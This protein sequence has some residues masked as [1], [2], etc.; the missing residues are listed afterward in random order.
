MY[1]M[2]NDGG[3]MTASDEGGAPVA[4]QWTMLDQQSVPAWVE[5]T[6]LL[7][8]VDGTEEFYSAEDLAEKLQEDG[9][10]P[11]H[12]SIAVW[13]SDHLAAFAQLRVKPGLTHQDGHVRA[14]ITAG[15]HP[16][17]R[18]RGIGRE[19][20][21]RIEQRAR[22]LAA[23]RHPGVPLELRSSGRL[24][25][26]PVRPF[27]AERGYSPARYFTAMARPLPGGDL[28]EIDPRAQPLTPDLHEA[29]RLAHNDAFASHWGSAPTSAEDWQHAVCAHA[30]RPQ[31][32][33]VVTEER[34][35]PSSPTVLAYCMAAQWVDRELYV[36]LVGTRPSARGRGLARAVLSATISTGAGSGAFEAIELDVDSQSPQGADT[37]YASLG[38]TAVR[39]TAVFTK[40]ESAP[41][42]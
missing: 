35:D 13:N 3:G 20:F 17:Y 1:T 7:A 28:G 8:Q 32:S 19:I 40:V 12:D 6:N 36:T 42:R 29:T 9:F 10:D 37:L 5:L 21:E 26:D 25:S 2:S 31:Y 22:I 18:G 41:P 30:A 39:T 16:R 15:V 24:A 4:L 33:F 38:F 34:A 23:E 11:A 27:L 14:Q